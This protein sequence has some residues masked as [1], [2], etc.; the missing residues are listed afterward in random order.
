MF[1]HTSKTLQTYK[2]NR[3]KINLLKALSDLDLYN[4]I[5]ANWTNVNLVNNSL[6]LRYSKST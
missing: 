6:L 1:Y 2:K 5:L 4:G 3:K